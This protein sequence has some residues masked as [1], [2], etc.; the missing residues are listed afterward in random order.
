[1]SKRDPMD[2]SRGDVELAIC[3]PFGLRQIELAALEFPP[4][5]YVAAGEPHWRDHQVRGWLDG[6]VAGRLAAECAMDPGALDRFM[7]DVQRLQATAEKENAPL[8]GGAR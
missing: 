2:W 8:A 7:Q 4:P 1:M 5:E 6:F 3:A